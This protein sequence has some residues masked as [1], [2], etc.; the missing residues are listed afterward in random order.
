MDRLVSR[1]TPSLMSPETLEAMFVQRQELATTLVERIREGVLTEA[2]HHSLLVGPRG[3]GKTHLVAL[4]YHRIRALPEI[5]DALRVAW[6]HEEEWGIDSFLDLL[7]RILRSLH[8]EYRDTDLVAQVEAIYA[9]ESAEEAR[10][11]AAD[12]LRTFVGERTLLVLM[13]NLDDVFKGLGDEGQKQFRAYLQEH[14]FTTILATSQS[15]FEGVSKRSFPF[16]G[17]FRAH[18]LTA[19]SLD[20]AAELLANIAA[21]EGKDDLA[22]FIRTPDGRARIRAVHHLAGGNPR[23]YVILSQFLTRESLDTLVEPFMLMLD[24]LTPYYQARMAWL[25]PQQRKIVEVLIEHRAALPVKQIAGRCFISPQSAS[26]QL[27]TLRE[28]G[29]VV[30]VQHGRESYYE[31]R[32]PLMRFSLAVKKQRAE[33]IRLF[34]DFLR[35]WYTRPELELQLDLLQPDAALDREYLLHALTETTEASDDPRVAACLHDYDRHINADELE[36]AL[37]ATDDLLTIRGEVEDWSKKFRCLL[38][39]DRFEEALEHSD[40]ALIRY[41]DHPFLLAGRSLA[42]ASLGKIA[43]GLAEAKHACRLGPDDA[44]V[45]FIA[46]ALLVSQNEHDK[47]CE[48]L[49]TATRLGPDFTDAWAHLALAQTQAGRH[50]DALTAL[51]QH[52]ALL[53]HGEAPSEFCQRARGFALTGVGRYREALDVLNTLPLD[54]KQKWAVQRRYALATLMVSGGESGWELL[55]ELPEPDLAIVFAAMLAGFG[56]WQDALD[57]LEVSVNVGPTEVKPSPKGM[58][59]WLQIAIPFLT[60]ILLAAP[61]ATFNER[62]RSLLDL[63]I[64]HER[65]SDLNTSLIASMSHLSSLPPARVQAWREAWTEA[66]AGYEAFAPALR[67]LDVAIEYQESEDPRVLLSLPVEE[68]VLLEQALGL[69]DSADEDQTPSA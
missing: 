52:D 10:V 38:G 43:E 22:A 30:S 34:V 15:L 63:S 50:A 11:Q 45:W 17:F 51:T 54:A 9:T 39:L 7:L 57:H 64:R 26:S 14:P 19:F 24:D 58:D 21:H 6:L 31:L 53:T 23:V 69:D 25:S 61:L 5:Q 40:Q 8:E 27:K 62:V 29:Y 55:P 47:A 3:I 28:S 42:L 67:M 59:R 60:A 32:E 36:A 2:K 16:Y 20:E 4:V 65:L 66:A 35:I 68:R 46:G 1:F 18:H 37:Q 33:P 44:A 41:P 12:L 48:A 56:S 49:E 13:E